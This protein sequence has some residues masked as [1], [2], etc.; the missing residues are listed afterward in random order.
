MGV[1]QDLGKMLF[2]VGCSAFFCQL[3]FNLEHPIFFVSTL[4]TQD[5]DEGKGFPTEEVRGKFKL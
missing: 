3:V 2:G 5:T 1:T 4:A